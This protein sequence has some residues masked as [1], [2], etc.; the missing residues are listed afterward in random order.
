[1]QINTELKQGVIITNAA[2]AL[3]E[4]FKIGDFMIIDDHL[5]IPALVGFSPLIGPNDDR[6]GPRFTPMGNI[7]DVEWRK[8]AKSVAVELNEDVKSGKIR[9]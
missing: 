6:I 8:I 3:N 2:G 4:S 9:I 1:M 5:N 7:Y